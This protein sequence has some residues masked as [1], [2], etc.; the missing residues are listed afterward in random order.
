ME[1]WTRYPSLMKDLTADAASLLE[2]YCLLGRVGDFQAAEDLWIKQLK[3]N[4]SLFL[5]SISYL[6]NMLRQSR[7]G[8][9]SDYLT[10]YQTSIVDAGKVGILPAQ[11]RVLSVMRAYLNVFTRGW[12]R[13]AI[14]KVRDTLEWLSA[15][16][17]EEYD[18]HQV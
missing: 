17:I 2:Q 13:A 3:Q 14:L 10:E 9:A 1:T 12:L 16:K 4:A 6:D 11:W 8:S 5:Y 15:T 18:D 7:Y